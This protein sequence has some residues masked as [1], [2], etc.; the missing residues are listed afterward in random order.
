MYGGKLCTLCCGPRRVGAWWCIV[1][2]VGAWWCIVYTVLWTEE[3]RCM[4][5]HCTVHRPDGKPGAYPAFI[6]KNLVGGGGKSQISEKW[7]ASRLVSRG[8]FVFKLSD[9]ASG[10]FLGTEESVLGLGL[11]STRCIVE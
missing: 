10:R 6:Q 2:R 5:V 11:I 9:I 8:S 3:G 4:V 1:L 7:G